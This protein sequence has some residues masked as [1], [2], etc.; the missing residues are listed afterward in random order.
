ML[1]YYV[2]RL[3]Q[4]SSFSPP[5]FL[6]PSFLSYTL[7]VLLYS[8]DLYFNSFSVLI[9]VCSWTFSLVFSCYITLIATSFSIATLSLCICRLIKTRKT[10]DVSNPYSH[11]PDFFFSVHR[12]LQIVIAS[13][14]FFSITFFVVLVVLLNS[15]DI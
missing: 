11:F 5:R 9:H 13:S 10:H 3:P 15:W 1:F 14:V 7:A 8:W 4:T 6:S 12:F 2:H